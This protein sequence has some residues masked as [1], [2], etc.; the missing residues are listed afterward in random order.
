MNVRIPQTLVDPLV[1]QGGQSGGRDRFGRGGRGSLGNR[2]SHAFLRFRGFRDIRLLFGL[3]DFLKFGFL[4]GGLRIVAV[5]G[6]GVL[7]HERPKGER[8]RDT[9]QCFANPHMLISVANLIVAD[10]SLLFQ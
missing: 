9:G 8:K 7:H 4:L 6:A 2:D 3:D 1:D 5:G 10:G